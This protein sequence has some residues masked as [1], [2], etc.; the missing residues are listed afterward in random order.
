M[1]GKIFKYSLNPQNII[2]PY[3]IIPLI[4]GLFGGDPLDILKPV[5]LTFIFYPA[6]NLWNHINDAEDD[7]RAGR[8]TPFLDDRAKRFG[9]AVVFTLYFL[10]AVCSYMFGGAVCLGFFA[11]VLSA[12][13]LYSDNMIFKV[14]LK[15][16]FLGELAVYLISIPAYILMLYSSVAEI[17]LIGIKLAILFTPLML[18]TVFIKD[19]KDISSDSNAGLLTLGVVFNPETLLKAFAF[20]ILLYFFFVFLMFYGTFLVV[21]TIPVFGVAA[22]IAG[23]AKHRW[24]VSDS[25]VKYYF[26]IFYSALLSVI[27]FLLAVIL[28]PGLESI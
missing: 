12:T 15:R 25:N 3:P 21:S 8:D 27:L 2:F 10:S 23:L 14:R 5:I 24:R 13:F 6:I 7:F 9:I 28:P 1:L 4:V 18:S 20:S 22:G 16:H 11:V 17:D 19:L 26:A